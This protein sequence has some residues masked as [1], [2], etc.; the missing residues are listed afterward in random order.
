MHGGPY[1]FSLIEPGTEIRKS[2]NVNE[3]NDAAQSGRKPII[4]QIILIH[5]VMFISRSL[6][7][8]RVYPT[9]INGM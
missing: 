8:L 3:T 6:W 9:I 7:A 5:P 1:L 2:Q 4:N